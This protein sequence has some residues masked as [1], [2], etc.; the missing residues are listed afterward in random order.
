MP[1]F[2]F[3][4]NFRWPSFSALRWRVLDASANKH[5][6]RFVR[7]DG[8]EHKLEEKSRSTGERAAHALHEHVE[9]V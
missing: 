2:F 8:G 5:F 6:R 4:R 1:S 3:G 9:R 7:S